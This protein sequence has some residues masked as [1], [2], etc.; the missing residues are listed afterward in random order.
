MSS[1]KHSLH[2]FVCNNFNNFFMFRTKHDV[3][4]LKR[5]LCHKKVYIIPKE[6]YVMNRCCQCDTGSKRDHVTNRL[7]VILNGNYVTNRLYVIL[8]ETYLTN[9]F[10]LRKTYF[11]NQLY[12]ILKGGICHKQALCHS[13]SDPCYK[14]TILFS[15]VTNRLYYSKSNLCHNY[16]ILKGTYVTNRLYYSKSNLC[17]KQLLYHPKGT[18]YRFYIILK[19]AYITNRLYIILKETCTNMLYYSKRNLCHKQMLYFF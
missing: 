18:C 17:Y 6:T 11:T 1:V 14:Q 10:K 8:K 15:N 7:Y 16:I 4:H 13:K 3:C 9:G 2:R 5:E 12:I 19:G